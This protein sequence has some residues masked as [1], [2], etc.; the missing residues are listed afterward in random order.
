MSFLILWRANIADSRE[1][2]D[3]NQKSTQ[4]RSNLWSLWSREKLN[5]T[6][7]WKLGLHKERSSEN[8]KINNIL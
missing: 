4:R 2:I 6:H 3:G 7:R 1:K 5:E 8:S